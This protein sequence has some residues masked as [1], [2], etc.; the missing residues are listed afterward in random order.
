MFI[1]FKG[2]Y[3][4]VFPRGCKAKG[5]ISIDRNA[6]EQSLEAAL[7]AAQYVDIPS[8]NK[9]FLIIPIAPGAR[10]EIT[11]DALTLIFEVEDP[12]SAEDRQALAQLI[13]PERPKAIGGETPPAET[14]DAPRPS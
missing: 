2:D 7:E 11:F 12:F 13:L 5:R 9:T 4:L 3:V 14:A 1:A 8:T 10:G 6:D